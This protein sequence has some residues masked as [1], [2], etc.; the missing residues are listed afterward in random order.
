MNQNNFYDT[1]RI[2]LSNRWLIVG[3]LLS[4]LLGWLIAN[5][6]ISIGV[7]SLVLPFGIAFLI[8]VFFNPRIG[9][10]SFIFY[11]FLMPTIGKHIVGLQ[12]GLLVDGLLVICWL[13]VFFYRGNRF[14][15]RHLNID[16]VWLALVWFGITV[17]EIGNPTRPNI[18]GWLQEMRSSSLYWLLVVPLTIFIFNKKTDISL[19]LNIIIAMSFLGAIYGLKQLYLGVDS[20]ENRWLEEGAKKTHILFGQLRVFSYYS[21]AAQ[22]GASQAHLAV[23]CLALAV[24]PY[25][26]RKKLWY[27]VAGLLIFYGMLI[28]GTR[29]A[30]GALVGG[31]FIFL[32]LM[33]QTRILV[34]GML[35]G[36][37][38]IGMLKFTSIGSGNDQ[39]RR[40]RSSLDPNDPSLQARLINQR[41]LKDIMASKPIGMGVGTIGQWGSTY[42]QHIATANIP[43]DS[44]YVKMWAMYGVIGFVI[45]FGMML[46]IVGKSSGI[47]WETR[48]PVLRNQLISLCAGSFGSLVCSYGNE[49]MNALPSSVIVY[50]SWA[51]VFASPKWDTK[52]KLEEPKISLVTS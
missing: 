17:L 44:L 31:G 6:G 13:A 46:Y 3:V 19:F 50:I 34:T 30:M 14:R 7:L 39:I 38:F 25:S 18:M 26:F 49:V 37:A 40:L 42:N 21:E 29:G 35:L 10:I 27:S 22:F 33:K 45:W 51:L 1:N 12:F 28:S 9:L 32:I 52:L 47:I 43:P 8:L 2:G 36:V 4:I 23:M 48:D 16:L 20:A 41:I 5:L 15:F 24:G 11:C